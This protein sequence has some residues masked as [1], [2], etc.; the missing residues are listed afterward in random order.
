MTISFSVV[1]RIPSIQILED[2]TKQKKF[3]IWALKFKILDSNEAQ[4]KKQAIKR[5]YQE[6][7]KWRN[8]RLAMY[9]MYP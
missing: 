7:T 4:R 9:E 2:K 1:E 5:L 6:K 3:E 8:P